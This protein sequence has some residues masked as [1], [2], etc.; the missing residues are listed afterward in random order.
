[1]IERPAVNEDNILLKGVCQFWQGDGPGGIPGL[2]ASLCRCPD[3]KGIWWVNLYIRKLS[4][5]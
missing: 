1:M 5:G 2:D 3:C 4:K